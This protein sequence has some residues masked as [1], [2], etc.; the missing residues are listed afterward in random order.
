[1]RNFP[2]Y[3][4]NKHNIEP[5]VKLVKRKKVSLSTWMDFWILFFHQLKKNVKKVIILRGHWVLIFYNWHYHSRGIEIDILSFLLWT[6]V[7][8]TPFQMHPRESP[9]FYNHTTSL[10]I[11]RRSWKRSCGKPANQHLVTHERNQINKLLQ[12][13]CYQCYSWLIGFNV[14]DD[15]AGVHPVLM[16]IVVRAVV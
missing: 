6:R 14:F 12:A 3:V 13:N 2:N 11:Q 10:Y 1:M 8:N 7:R 4:W 9:L 15:L 16:F 5:Y